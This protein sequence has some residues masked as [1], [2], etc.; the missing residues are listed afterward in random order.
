[1]SIVVRYSLLVGRVCTPQWSQFWAVFFPWMGS[2]LF[3]QGGLFNELIAWSGDLAIGPVNFVLPLMLTLTALGVSGMVPRSWTSRAA[4]PE[5]HKDF[6][7]PRDRNP[8][9]SEMVGDAFQAGDGSSFSDPA[10]TRT[11]AE[12]LPQ[13]LQR[14][15]RPIAAVLCILLLLIIIT[16]IATHTHHY[17]TARSLSHAINYFETAR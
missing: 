3:Y 8:S 16:S 9:C 13:E 6:S 17:V 4:D 11:A 7:F 15:H 14:Y 1:M 5:T 12:P 10:N 2:W